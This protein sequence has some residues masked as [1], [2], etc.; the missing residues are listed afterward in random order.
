MKSLPWG[1]AYGNWN[2]DRPLLDDIQF[3][4]EIS[5]DTSTSVGR[6]FQ[7]YDFKIG[8]IGQYFGL[9]T[10]LNRPQSGCQGNGLIFSRWCEANEQPNAAST[11]CSEN[12]FI[13]LGRHEGDFVGVRRPVPWKSGRF[14][15]SIAPTDKTSAATWFEFSVEDLS[16]SERYS[17]GQLAFPRAGIENGGGTWIETYSGAASEGQVPLTELRVL[18]VRANNGT[19]APV[20]CKTNYEDFQKS[21]AFV[22]QGILVLRAGGSVSRIHPPQEFDLR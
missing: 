5:G 3:E 13:E 22:D 20:S 15:C 4:I 1:M 21:D 18:S 10:N 16:T 6:Y 8:G 19:L 17:C 12:G 2:F 11:R 9:Q 14:R 7:L